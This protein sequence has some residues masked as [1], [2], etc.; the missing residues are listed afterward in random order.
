MKEAKTYQYLV[1]IDEVGRG[2]LAGPVTLAS[3]CV[4]AQNLTLVKKKLKGITDSKKLSAKRRAEFL[5]VIKQLKKEGLI[6]YA[7]SS[8]SAKAIDQR[9][10]SKGIQGAIAQVLLKLDLP[11]EQSFVYL[12]GSLKASDEYNQVT[13]I[14][15]DLHNWLISA[16]SVIAKEYR[17]SLMKRYGKKYPSYGFEQHMGYG[18]RYHREMIQK[19]GIC[20]IH[21]QSYIH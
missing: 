7:I 18:T 6:S 20:D 8:R 4:K 3:F 9:G 10:I 21:R 13:I 12:D 15:G 5:G 14:K 11:K 1:G 19:H 17:D 2:P 16:A